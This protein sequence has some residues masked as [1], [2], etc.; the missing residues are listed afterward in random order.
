MTSQTSHTRPSMLVSGAGSGIGLAIAQKA[1]AAG[2]DL[3]LVDRSRTSLESAESELDDGQAKVVTVVADV[4]DLAALADGIASTRDRRGPLSAVAHS[5][6]IEVLG[7]VDELDPAEWARCINVN[8]T[9]SFNVA[10]AAMPELLETR[11]AL[12]FVASD[13]G[14][15][16]AQG[17][18][19]YCASKHGVVGLMRAMALDYGPRGVRVNAVAPSFVETPMA[20]RIFSGYEGERDF[21]RTTVPL[22]R[23]AAPSEI[24]SVVLHLLSDD[25]SFTTGAVYRVD[26]GSTAGYFQPPA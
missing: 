22:G 6:G 15:T 8:L 1:A 11:G 17:Y 18:A 25:A 13:A 7:A 20:D 2:Y 26:G 9:G 24:A 14:I 21:Y 12:A 4:T 19:A 23:F 10:R 3:V 5:A 16:G